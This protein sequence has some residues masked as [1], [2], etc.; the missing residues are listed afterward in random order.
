MCDVTVRH[1]RLEVEQRGEKTGC[2]VVRKHIAKCFKGYP[3][4]AHL[5]KRL[6]AEE[7]STGMIAV[8]EEAARAGDPRL[9]GAASRDREDL[10]S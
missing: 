6:Y 8:L 3:G 7:T 10:A 1:I 5:R 4:A 9:H 2:L